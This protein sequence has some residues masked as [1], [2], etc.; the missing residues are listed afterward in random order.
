MKKNYKLP[1]LMGLLILIS[2]LLTGIIL[3]NTRTKLNSEASAEKAP[4]NI[5][6]SNISPEGFTVTWTTDSPSYGYIKYGGNSNL[7]SNIAEDINKEKSTTHFVNLRSVKSGSEV[8]YIINSESKDWDNNGVPWQSILPDS[9][10]VIENVNLSGTIVNPEGSPLEK[11]LVYIS[12]NGE[13]Y[14]TYTSVNGSW[15]ISLPIK[16]NVSEN[17]HLLEI[18]VENGSDINSTATIFRKSAKNTPV[19]VLG[20][21]YDFRTVPENLNGEPPEGQISLPEE[22][23]KTSRFELTETNSSNMNL[24]VTVE[25]I[26]NGEIINSTNPEFFGSGPKDTQINISIQSE[27]QTGS[28]FTDSSGSWNWTPPENLEPGEHTLSIDW[29]DGNGIMRTLT[30][31][32]IVSAAEGPAFEATPS[33]T[34]SE[35]PTSTPVATIISTASAT[36]FPV[37]DTGNLTPTLGLFIM[38]ISIFFAG[39][40]FLKTADER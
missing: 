24:S 22:I 3:V 5:R 9:K 30:R 6:V 35:K 32:F 34:P 40:Y 7:L 20:K 13:F 31:K 18:F 37:P 16:D 15:L 8:Y 4:K 29:K 28:V 10:T 12:S 36:A 19:I 21:N 27:L 11:A 39:I 25:N 17:N 2:G 26:E 14:S 1:T 33:A 23:E 38:G